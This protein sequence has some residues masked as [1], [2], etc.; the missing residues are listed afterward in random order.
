MPNRSRDKQLAKLAARRQAERHAAKR[1]RDIT[2][3][4]VG[5]VIGLALLVVGYMV[6]TGDDDATQAIDALDAHGVGLGGALGRAGHPVG[7]GR[8]AWR[9]RRRA[10]RATVKPPPTRARRRHSSWDRRR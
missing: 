2:L 9:S 6:L 5:G 3:G 8:T 4:V 7:S 10:W 1:R